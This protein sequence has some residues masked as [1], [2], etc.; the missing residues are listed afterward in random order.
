MS[1]LK[2]L[3]WFDIPGQVVLKQG[4]RSQRLR[5]AP[6]FAAAIQ[7]AGYRVRKQGGDELFDPWRQEA[8]PTNGADL[9]EQARQLVQRLEAEYDD[10]RLEQLV[11]AG[12]RQVAVEV[13]QE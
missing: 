2:V 1:R 11:R 13:D 10:H 6:R 12:G 4:R 7:R 3:Y 5:L 8:Q 9:Q